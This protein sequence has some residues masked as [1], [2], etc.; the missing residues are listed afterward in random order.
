VDLHVRETAVQLVMETRGK[1]HASA[2]LDAIARGGYVAGI[3]R[4]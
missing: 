4:G 3:I 2:V 1:D